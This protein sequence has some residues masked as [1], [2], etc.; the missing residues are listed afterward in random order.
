MR[1][2]VSTVFQL[3]IKVSQLLFGWYQFQG[4]WPVHVSF[5]LN[6]NNWENQGSWFLLSFGSQLDPKFWF[7]PGLYNYAIVYLASIFGFEDLTVKFLEIDEYLQGSGFSGKIRGR[8]A[9]LFSLEVSITKE[10]RSPSSRNAGKGC[11][12]VPALV[13][14][15]ATE[16]DDHRASRPF[17]DS[18]SS[19]SS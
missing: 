6:Q 14:E 16:S 9:S 19:A 15:R 2:Q 3:Q 10:P 18:Y 11:D 12:L 5:V 1:D 17:E 13:S 8:M 4:S 7:F